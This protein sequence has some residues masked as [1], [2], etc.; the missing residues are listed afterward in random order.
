MLQEEGQY[1]S[2][3]SLA[4]GA[5]CI[6]VGIHLYRKIRQEGTKAQ[7]ARL[8]VLLFALASIEGTLEFLQMVAPDRGSAVLVSRFM[9]PL[10]S[11]MA[12][13]LA[14][15][16][17]YMPYPPRKACTSGT[18]EDFLIKLHEHRAE[19]FGA[20]LAFAAGLAFLPNDVVYY[21]GTWQADSGAIT[22]RIWI[23]AL[24]VDY[25]IAYVL[26]LYRYNHRLD[27]VPMRLDDPEPEHQ[28]SRVPY[29]EMIVGLSVV[30]LFSGV[31]VLAEHYSWD[32]PPFIGMSLLLTALVFLSVMKKDGV[33]EEP[34]EPE[35][36]SPYEQ[37]AVDPK[38]LE[39]RMKAPGA[40]CLVESRSAD[41]AYREFL[42]RSAGGPCMVMSR[43][44]PE[45]VKKRLKGS[46]AHTIWLTSS[47]G[48]DRVDPTSLT[49]IQ[50]IAIDFLKKN[51]P[52]ALLLDGLE[53]MFFYNAP[54]KVL[55]MVYAVTDQLST[56]H[57]GVLVVPV[58]PDGMAERELA[59]LERESTVIRDKAIEQELKAKEEAEENN[60][61]P[62]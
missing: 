48:P 56:V 62:V 35:D 6:A 27:P 53:D 30:P 47:P 22:Y 10:A 21:S 12:V 54:D 55:K 24:L 52:P 8:M 3:L 5:L 40:M 36:G 25:I 38:A 60:E 26:L 19:F 41:L 32:L 33:F 15:M 20:A 42:G 17:T 16:I 7:G 23:S 59:L 61:R 18:G 13:L 58:N 37:G 39:E 31:D 34:P 29:V 57:G 4:A 46:R 2:L 50:N 45:R 43:E 44:H 11:I 14:Y 28:R 51:Q 9:L 49:I 1:F